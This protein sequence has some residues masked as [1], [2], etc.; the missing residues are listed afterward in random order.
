MH[1]KILAFCVVSVFVLSA[2][3]SIVSVGH[4][5]EPANDALE[6]TR[7]IY[8]HGRYT[9]WYYKPSSYAQLVGWYQSLEANF[10]NY[11]E[12]FKAN[13]MYGTGNVSG[14]YD[15]WYVRIT[16]ESRGLHKPEV[17]FSGGPHGDETVG[18]I[19]L[20]WFTDWMMRK[21][22][23]NESSP[24]YSKDWLH[25]LLNN[26]EIYIE[27]SHNP[28]G[29]DHDQRYDSHGW[30]LNREADFNGP[31]SN[32]PYIWGSVPGQ[33]M[34]H[35]V[36]N[37]TIR[38]GCD[39]HGGTRLL[40]YPFASTHGSI[41]GTSPVSGDTYDS[42]PPDFYFFDTSSLRLGQFMGNP[43]GEGLLDEDKVGTIDSM[44]WYTVKGGMTPW[45]YAAD[46]VANP[47]EDPYVEDETFGNYPG[48]GVLWVTPEMSY[49]KNPP[50][51]DFGNDTTPG[52][53][54]E[55]RRYV[56]HQTDI[57]QPSVRWR[58]DSIA[59]N[60]TVNTSENI[61]FKWEV[62]GCMVVDN[63]SIQWGT[64]PDPVNNSDFSTA[65]H[66]EHAGDYVGGSG[67][68]NA[69]D[70]VKAGTVYTEN[71]TID[72]PGTYYFVAK[73]KVD[74]I[75]NQTL[76]PYEYGDT[77]YLRLI[78]ERV[79]ASYYEVINGTDGIEEING[80]L[81]WHSPVVK[82]AVGSSTVS[83]EYNLSAGW[84]L[85]TVP[86]ANDFNASSLGQSMP[87][88]EIVAYWN[89]SAGMFESYVV[90]VTPGSGFPIRDGV[91]YFVYVNT[92][93]SFSVTG[94]PLSSVAVDLHTGWNTIGWFDADATNASSLASSVPN[95]SIAAYW[96]ASSGTFESYTVG[97]TPPPGFAVNRGMGVFVYVTSPGTWTGQG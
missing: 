95:C 52:F 26:R 92:S 72:T 30:D 17:F 9:D 34:Y 94:V 15:C 3:N 6:K 58:Q 51:S 27:V 38:A 61:T 97:V 90:G 31:G 7:D 93:S 4:G 36:N 74:Q 44:I 37:H 10:S 25:W 76:A 12:T 45:G 80:Q 48:A 87:N 71:I 96:D 83:N 70:G 5:E 69:S 81:W 46:V 35:F 22:L 86:V 79:N 91:G 49:T 55:V 32:A 84:N 19:G 50:E 67:W 23:T 21:A 60:A 77:P 89:A 42:A 54:W 39:F 24:N 53:G 75:Y 16:N 2:G 85:V 59:D 18:A 29:F 64:D 33:T 73:A 63:T 82:V 8:E 66:T 56:L 78:K 28:Y 65:P 13:Q 43:S 14:G 68:D 57:A 20:Y 47:V 40:L 11:I 62:N 41:S 88:C 1:K